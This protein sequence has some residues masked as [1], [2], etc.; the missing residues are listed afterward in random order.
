[1]I[2]SWD[3]TLLQI[4]LLYLIHFDSN[5]DRVVVEV[6]FNSPFELGKDYGRHTH[7]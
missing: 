6:L 1:M 2:S 7:F 5:F 4:S 3:L